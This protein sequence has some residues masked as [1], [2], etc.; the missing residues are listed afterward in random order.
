[1]ASEPEAHAVTAGITVP[2]QSCLMAIMPE[3]MLPI[4]MG[5]KSGDT[6][7]GPFSISF[8]CS[9]SKVLMPPMPVPKMTEKRSGSTLP[10]TPLSATAC[11]AAATASCSYLSVRR[12]SLTSR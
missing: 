5:M 3:A 11:A 10:F 2:R 7:L 9:V 8:L 6:R 4:I 12:I 1:M